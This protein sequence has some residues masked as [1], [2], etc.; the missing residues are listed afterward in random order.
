MTLGIIPRCYLLFQRGR[1]P[2][3]SVAAFKRN[4]RPASTEIAGR[5]DPEY[6]VLFIEKCY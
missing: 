4:T 1:F 5:I 2:P 6:A 3:E